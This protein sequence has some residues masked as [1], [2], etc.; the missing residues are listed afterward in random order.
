M[1][2][3]IM[4]L[5]VVEKTKH[6]MLFIIRGINAPFVNTIRRIILE[7]VPSMAIDEVVMIENSSVLHDELL[8]LRLG[9]I[10]L[11]TDLDS[12]NLQEE[13]NCNSE[14]G[15]NLC[16]TIL[17]LDYEAGKEA[18][19]V[20][21]KDIISEDP[22]IIPV[23][24]KIPIVKLAPN[25]KVRLEAYAKLGKG[26]DHAKWQPVYV[27]TYRYIPK[28]EIDS[29]N[30]DS[31]GDC[32][33]I[34]PKNIFVKNKKDIKIQ[35]MMDCILCFDC[36]KACSVDPAPIKVIGDDSSFIFYLESSGGLPIQRIISEALKIYEE[37]YTEFINH[38]KVIIDAP[39]KKN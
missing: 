33:D 3:K 19:T 16:R 30:C 37:K 39:E 4:D 20:Y 21:S 10:P 38:L 6:S 17:T 1:R 29:A 35:N 23:S 26:K 13:C 22:N 36:V 11:N 7:E 15:C 32:V 24:K 18:V 31:C 28:I 34:C 25:Q 12:Y 8:A 2:I 9:L 27:C 14:L 5:K